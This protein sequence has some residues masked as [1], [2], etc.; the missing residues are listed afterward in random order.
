MGTEEV[1]G[2]R[3]PGDTARW[4]SPTGPWLLVRRMRYGYDGGLM[5]ADPRTP[6]LPTWLGG[7]RKRSRTQKDTFTLGYAVSEK[8]LPLCDVV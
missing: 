8:P 3:V 7:R 1:F 2:L 4:D 5:S 6:P